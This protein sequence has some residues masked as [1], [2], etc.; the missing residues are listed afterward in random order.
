MTSRAKS[1]IEE[2]S[3]KGPGLRSAVITG[4]LAFSEGVAE[5]LEE[6]LKVPV[7]MGAVKQMH[8]NISGIESLRSATAIGLARYAALQYQPKAV[9]AK[10]L[11]HGI[12]NKVIEIFNNYF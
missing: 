9:Q 2:F 5:A 6:A 8:G 12:S 3:K 7:R 11:V 1:T 4:D 10:K